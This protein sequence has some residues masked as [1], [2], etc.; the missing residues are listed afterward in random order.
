MVTTKA[1]TA[2]MMPATGTIQRVVIEVVIRP[3]SVTRITPKDAP[4]ETPVIYGS[5]SGLWIMACITAPA[6]ARPAPTAITA[7]ARG[8]LSV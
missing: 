1:A 7:I 4:D 8:I 6:A 2:P 3:L 5:T